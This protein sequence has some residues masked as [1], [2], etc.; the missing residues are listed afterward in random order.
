MNYLAQG[1]QQG[2]EIGARSY[3]NKK[4]R[5]QEDDLAAAERQLRVDQQA[6]ELENRRVLQEAEQTFRGTQGAE[7]RAARSIEAE[8][9]RGWQSGENTEDRGFRQG[10]RIDSQGFQSSESA[11]DRAA[12]VIAQDKQLAQQDKELGQRRDFHDIELPLAG[13]KLGLQARAQDWREN[14][15]NPQNMALGALEQYRSAAAAGKLDDMNAFTINGGA[16]SPSQLGAAKPPPAVN[17]GRPQLAGTVAPSTPPPA[18]IDM[19]R[20]NPNLAGEFDR[21]YGAG[22]AAKIMQGGAQR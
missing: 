1:L 8:K 18:A 14:P 9:Q 19:L 5:K 4:K 12:K 11:L 22:T 2:A 6:K 13:A 15:E 3:E 21:K 16:P 17:G 10:E 7:E 20:R